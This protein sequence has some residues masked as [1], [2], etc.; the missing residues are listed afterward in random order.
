LREW[1]A[2]YS[3]GYT[4]IE[5]VWG[6][7]LDVIRLAHENSLSFLLP[8]AFCSYC[9]DLD[10]DDIF[11]GLIRHD[12]TIAFLSTEDQLLCI[13]ARQTLIQRQDEIILE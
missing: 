7:P 3:C 11:R 12:G 10:F 8:A 9:D 13:K 6:E 5:M 1:D 2:V 4:F